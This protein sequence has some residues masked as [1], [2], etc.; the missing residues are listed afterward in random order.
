MHA[1]RLLPG[2]PARGLYPAQ[3]GRHQNA[4]KQRNGQSHTQGQGAEHLA[5]ALGIVGL[6]LSPP[7]PLRIMKNSALPRLAKMARKARMITNFMNG[8]SGAHFPI[9]D[10]W[11]FLLISAAALICVAVTASLGFWQLGRAAQ[12]QAVFDAIARQQALQ[13][14]HNAE[15]A[16]EVAL[17]AARR[18]STKAHLLHSPCNC[19]ASGWPS[20]PSSGQPPDAGPRRL[21]CAHALQAERSS[22]NTVVVVRWLGAAQLHG[23]LGSA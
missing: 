1:K 18:R 13:P 7:S 22:P 11:R 8:L 21:L 20:R 23:P 3:L 5:A 14:W 4:E 17:A 9:S 6:E 10:L 2:L 12:K 19:K 15:L 16:A